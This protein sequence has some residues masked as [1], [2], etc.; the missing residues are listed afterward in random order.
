MLGGCIVP[1]YRMRLG[2]IDNALLGDQEY[3]FN[4]HV[5]GSNTS[6]AWG[7]AESI[8]AALLEA[9]MPTTVNLTSIGVANPD[10]VN[11]TLI[12]PQG[13]AGTRAVTGD[14]LPGWNVVRL[15]F[16]ASL[17]QRIHTFFLRMGLTEDDVAGQVLTSATSL[18]VASAV[19]G[20]LAAETLCD[21]DGQVFGNG[22]H[23][24]TVRMRQMGWRRRS[25]PG[26]KR[27]WV[28]V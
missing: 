25:R 11:G 3:S 14:A 28:P 15:Q 24:N 22:D 8:A 4:G 21:K 6:V 20:I 7:N 16:S 27:G 13:S 2:F 9:V 5:E 19:N 10:V 23:S 17:G 18:A 12:I 1:V 26:Y